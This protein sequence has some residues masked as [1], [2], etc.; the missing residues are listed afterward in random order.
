[1]CARYEYGG[2][3]WSSEYPAWRYQ[4]PSSRTSRARPAGSKK[5]GVRRTGHQRAKKNKKKRHLPETGALD[6]SANS[7]LMFRFQIRDVSTD[8]GVRIVPTRELEPTPSKRP[9]LPSVSRADS[10]IPCDLHRTDKKPAQLAR[11][12]NHGSRTIVKHRKHHTYT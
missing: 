5:G 7:T 11:G 12:Q 4:A 6:R 9:V 10:L 2:F 8:R 1:M 3:P